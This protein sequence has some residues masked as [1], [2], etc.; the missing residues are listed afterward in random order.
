[1]LSDVDDTVDSS[2]LLI[3]C[4]QVECQ[5]ETPPSSRGEGGGD[6]SKEKPITLA[7][8]GLH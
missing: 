7:S 4:T 5:R 1:M 2:S 8:D 3:G 6:L